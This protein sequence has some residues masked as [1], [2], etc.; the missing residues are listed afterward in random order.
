MKNVE[1]QYRLAE[2]LMVENG[3]KHPPI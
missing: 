1:E 2:K 3:E